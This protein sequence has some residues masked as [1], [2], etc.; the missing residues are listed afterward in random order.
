MLRPSTKAMCSFKELISPREL[1][2]WKAFQTG[3]HFSTKDAFKKTQPASDTVGAIAMDKDGSICVGTSTGGT[4]NKH[5]GRVGDSP[6]I[7]CGTY[8]D[9]D[10]GGVSYPFFPELGKAFIFIYDGYEGGI[11]ISEKLYETFKALVQMTYNLIKDC[12]CEEGCP[13]CILSSKCGNNNR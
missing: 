7:G 5:P 9:N 3:E 6:L 1:S 10:I 12:E 13:A 11:G 4:F 8:A 2:K